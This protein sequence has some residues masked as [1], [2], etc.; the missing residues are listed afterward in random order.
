MKTL[1]TPWRIDHV[2]GKAPK[3]EHCIFEPPG[4]EP[5]NKDLLLLYKNM[6]GIVLL[7][8]FP[9]TNGHLLIAPLRH[10]GCITELTE[11]ENSELMLLIQKATKIL[12][13]YLR[14]D[15]FNIGCNLGKTAGA[16][17]ADHLHFHIVP[18]WDGDH[19]FITVVSDI[20]TIPEHIDNTFDNL[21]PD[22]TTLYLQKKS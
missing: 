9:Y 16:G 1:W 22:F 11:K 19:N 14:P 4:H 13:N 15:G 20:R 17:I 8:R 18:R 5:S 12:K 21:L 6:D 2:L 10:I 3:A 7:N